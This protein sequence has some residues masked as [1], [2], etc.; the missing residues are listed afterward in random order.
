MAR[1]DKLFDKIVN[2]DEGLRFEEVAK[3]LLNEGYSMDNPR[4]GSSHYSF[5]KPNRK[6]L[7]IPKKS[8]V[9]KKYVRMVKE[10]L[11]L[12]RKLREKEGRQDN[13]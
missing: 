9:K 12:E 3:A 5:R 8:P 13:E 2:L 6:G 4:G 7:T 11:L 10:T 1:I